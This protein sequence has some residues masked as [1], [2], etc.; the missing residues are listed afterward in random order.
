MNLLYNFNMDLD[1]KNFECVRAH[2][3]GVTSSTTRNVLIQ[4]YCSD[5]FGMINMVEQYYRKAEQNAILI[6]FFILV[7]F[8][9]LFMLIGAI[10][11]NYLS[12]GMQDLAQKFKLSPAL[13][14]VT[15]IAFAN[16]APDVI[17]SLQAGSAPGGELI[18]LAGFYG[19]FMFCSTMAAANV[20]FNAKGPV[21]LPKIAILKELLFY[22][23]AVLVVVF[24]GFRQSTGYA[25]VGIYLVV[26]ACYIIL[27]VVTDKGVGEEVQSQNLT[28]V[29]GE[30]DIENTGSV[31]IQR[32]DNDKNSK[33]KSE[34]N[35]D[36]EE[37]NE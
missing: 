6:F 32:D 34:D 1:M 27:S 18:S 3:E 20:I 35:G 5:E 33:I 21:V 17:S 8:P 12:V 37:L 19:G 11:D 26:Y 16:G 7:I 14:A 31:Q 4:M 9:M 30:E 2:V 36:N 22:L 10:A 15:L 24:F 29:G 28:E 23:F 25:F 13:A